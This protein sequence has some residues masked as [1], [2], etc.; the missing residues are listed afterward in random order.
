MEKHKQHL[1]TTLKSIKFSACGEE[2]A[3]KDLLLI[4]MKFKKRGFERWK[5]NP[6][7]SQSK[8][9]APKG[10]IVKRPRQTMR[11]L[12]KNV[13]AS[14]SVCVCVCLSRKMCP[15]HHPPSGSSS[16]SIRPKKFEGK[17]SKPNNAVLAETVL[18]S[19]GFF[20]ATSPFGCNL[21][22]IQLLT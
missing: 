8:I 20:G 19:I 14:V 10:P 16:F 22:S 21:V 15:T 4:K 18:I 3:K 6:A 5:K 2:Y 1:Q 12:L 13:R 17:K 7:L 11:S 9:I